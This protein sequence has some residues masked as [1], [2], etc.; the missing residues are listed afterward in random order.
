[1]L[2]RY[3]L[4]SLEVAFDPIFEPIPLYGEQLDNRAGNRLIRMK[5]AEQQVNVLANPETVTSG[6]SFHVLTT[7]EF[8]SVALIVPF[9]KSRI[10][11]TL[12]LKSLCFSPVW[13][14]P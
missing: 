12:L 3:P 9:S 8:P 10:T 5:Y 4:E 14:Q 7:K 13:R 11:I 6:G 2:A 1:M